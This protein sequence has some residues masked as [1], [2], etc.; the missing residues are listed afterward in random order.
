M[1]SLAA[2]EELPQ[3][4]IAEILGVPVGTVYSRMNQARETLREALERAS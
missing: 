2:V 3:T 1:F 4:E